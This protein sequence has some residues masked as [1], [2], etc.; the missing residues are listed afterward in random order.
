MLLEVVM[1]LGVFIFLVLLS[2]LIILGIVVYIYWDELIGEQYYESDYD[3]SVDWPN[4]N[5]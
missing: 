1:Q 3:S 4:S 2:I 5:E